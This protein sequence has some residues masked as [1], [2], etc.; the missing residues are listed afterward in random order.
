L[1]IAAKT[2]QKRFK[3]PEGLRD[4]ISRIAAAGA[5]RHPYG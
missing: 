1:G 5:S 2:I 4:K 3:L